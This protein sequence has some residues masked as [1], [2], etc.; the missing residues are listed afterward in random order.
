MSSMLDD[1]RAIQARIAAAPP[2]P[3]AFIARFD[4]PFGKAF[5]MWDTRGRFVVYVHRVW[6]MDSVRHERSRERLSG[7]LDPAAFGIDVYFEDSGPQGE[8]H[9]PPA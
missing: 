2:Q 1:L 3:R 6:L 5:R 7:V 9:P 8:T 4:V